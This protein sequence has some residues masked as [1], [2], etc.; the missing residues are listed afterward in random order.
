[1][2]G[3]AQL[4]PCVCVW[5]GRMRTRGRAGRSGTEEGCVDVY[6]GSRGEGRGEDSVC[7]GQGLRAEG[8]AL[9]GEGRE[10]G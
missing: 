4:C 8:L 1:M 3:F 10:Q 7:G 6:M 2:L 9:V 5:G